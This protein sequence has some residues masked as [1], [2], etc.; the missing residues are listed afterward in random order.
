MV[1]GAPT[2]PSIEVDV[3]SIATQLREHDAGRR[4]SEVRRESIVS[5]S[6][7]LA[8]LRARADALRGLVAPILLRRLGRRRWT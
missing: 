6:P 8:F 5:L 3:A 4:D 2:L 7:S 1:G